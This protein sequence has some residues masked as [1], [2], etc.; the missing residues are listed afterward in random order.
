MVKARL[1][2]FMRKNAQGEVML[3]PNSSPRNE[4]LREHLIH[5]HLH[6]RTAARVSPCG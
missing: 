5:L 1:P 3:L 2:Y 6:G 4:A